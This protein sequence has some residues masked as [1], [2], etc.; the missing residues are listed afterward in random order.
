VSVA[1]VIQNAKRMR[2]I[3]S[4]VGSPAL[5]HF[6]TLSHKRHNF[7]KKLLNMKCVFRFSTQILPETF[8]VLKILNEILS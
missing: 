1:L 2:R 8:I 4:S 6:S 3:M 7:R 5:Q